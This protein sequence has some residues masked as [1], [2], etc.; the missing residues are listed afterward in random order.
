MSAFVHF[1]GRA[2]RAS[3]APPLAKLVVTPQYAPAHSTDLVPQN[4]GT[5]EE[6]A[7]K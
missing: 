2:F 1:H 5:T 6:S 4:E 7:I 3:G